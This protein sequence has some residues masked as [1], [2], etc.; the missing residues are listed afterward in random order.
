MTK[1]RPHRSKQTRVSTD[2]VKPITVRDTHLRLSDRDRDK[3]LHAIDHP[4]APTKKLIKALETS[5]PIKR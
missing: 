5:R 3:V 2:S 4:P 1:R